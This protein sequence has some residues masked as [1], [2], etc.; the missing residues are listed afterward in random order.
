VKPGSV[1]ETLT[2]TAK[3]DVGKLTMDDFLIIAVEQIIFT[4]IIIEM[5][6]RISLILSRL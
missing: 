5:H 4:G 2:E 3:G 6:L 1:T